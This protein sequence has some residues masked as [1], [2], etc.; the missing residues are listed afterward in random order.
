VLKR[1]SSFAHAALAPRAI[2][3]NAPRRHHAAVAT[4]PHI[5]QGYEAPT[6]NR[7]NFARAPDNEVVMGF[8]RFGATLLGGI[9]TLFPRGALRA[10]AVT[11]RKRVTR[12]FLL[13]SIAIWKTKREIRTHENMAGGIA[14]PTHR[15]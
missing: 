8:R 3:S 14:L 15:Y 6:R 13:S 4:T 10:R 5:S 7:S 1:P 12:N 11:L 9:V 2:N